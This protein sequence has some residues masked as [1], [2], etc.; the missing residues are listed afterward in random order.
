MLFLHGFPESRRCWHPY[1]ERFA[2]AGFRA[3]A[4][5]Q[6]GYADSAKPAALDAYGLDALA[7]DAIGLM[8]WAGREKAFVVGH[9]WGGAV[10]WWLANRSPERVEKLAALNV[11]HPAC[12][13]RRMLADP[14]QLARSWYI[15]CF[16]LP[17]L[18]ERLLGNGSVMRRNL[19]RSSRPGAFSGEE[20][21]ALQE[22]WSRPGAW[23]GMLN[24]YRAALRRPPRPVPPR[25]A[26]PTLILWG[27]GDRFLL[28]E[29]ADDSLALCERGTLERFP[30]ATHWI[31][32]EEAERVGAR[33]LSWFSEPARP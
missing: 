10:A 22:E 6:R 31:A 30:D 25:V 24:W 21:D 5:D 9:D 3:L 2:A 11:P 17:W 15:A 16:Q 4:P 23:S 33:L 12:L 18:P 14:R 26:P 28:P 20:L 19:R 13:R 27:D 7:D 29:L 8:R 1:L 32:R